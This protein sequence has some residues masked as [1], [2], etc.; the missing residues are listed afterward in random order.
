MAVWLLPL[1]VRTPLSLACC[2]CAVW[3]CYDCALLNANNNLLILLLNADVKNC[4]KI[5]FKISVPSNGRD[6]FLS[7]GAL[8][9]LCRLINHQCDETEQ[10][11]LFTG[12]V[13]PNDRNVC[14]SESRSEGPL[15]WMH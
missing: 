4:E 2:F 3:Y 8:E 15:F 1:A 14:C 13:G 10:N 9:R 5:T 6:T 7:I 11:T 12:Y